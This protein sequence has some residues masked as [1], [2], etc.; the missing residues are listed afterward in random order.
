MKGNSR[1]SGKRDGGKRFEGRSSGERGFGGRGGSRGF[2]NRDRGGFDRRGSDRPQMHHAICSN[3]GNDCEVPFKPTGDK[4]V[5]CSDCFKKQDHSSSNRF[6]SKR[7]DRPRFGE[8]KMFSAICDNCGNACE[9]PF[10]PTGEKPVFCS[11]C[12]AKNE[13]G[14]P[15]HV[16]KSDSSRSESY[17]K[18]FKMLNEK[19]DQ[20]LRQISNPSK[21]KVAV[22]MSATP[23]A[24]TE[25]KIKKAKVAKKVVKK[26][27]KK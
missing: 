4:P 26:A 5:F 14:A 7:F 11:N 20:I 21:S 1:F 24:K 16:K 25:V 12:F 19:L 17:D 27:K 2:G 9:V 13:G 6:E 18:Q 15:S 3:C 23:L 8:K 10:R 22:E